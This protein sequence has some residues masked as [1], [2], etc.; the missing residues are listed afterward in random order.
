MVPNSRAAKANPG[1]AIH[2]VGCPGGRCGS[3]AT[4]ALTCCT[5]RTY[6]CPSRARARFPATFPSG[7]GSDFVGVVTAA[8]PGAGQ[9]T[10]GDEVLGWTWD[11]ASHAEYVLVPAE[12]VVPKPAGLSWEAAGSLYVAG[13]TA[14]GAVKAAGARD[15]DVVRS[16]PR[17]AA[18]AA[19][20]SGCCG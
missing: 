15:G 5:S 8:G 18:W 13:A 20:S 6:R 14:Y 17:P 2:I 9:I 7:E 10:A 19:W 1:S 3:T 11:C 4:A 16:R 12:Q